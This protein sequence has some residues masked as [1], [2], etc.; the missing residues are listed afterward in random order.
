MPP[1]KMQAH[2]VFDHLSQ[3]VEDVTV[4][5]P[6]QNYNSKMFEEAAPRR[7]KDGN[8]KYFDK[9]CTK[10]SW[11]VKLNLICCTKTSHSLIPPTI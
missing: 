10:I 3:M 1:S 7:R 2:M 4:E 5:W 6:L 9:M 8:K 11:Y